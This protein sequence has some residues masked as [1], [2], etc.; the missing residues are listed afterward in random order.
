MLIIALAMIRSATPCDKIQLQLS[1]CDATVVSA[2][3]LIKKQKATIV[4]YERKVKVLEDLL[5]E[6][7]ITN[8]KQEEKIIELDNELS[9]FWPVVIGVGAATFGLGFGAGALIFLLL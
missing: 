7:K 2:G 3:R 8:K 6:E 5:R 9:T 1:K 4:I